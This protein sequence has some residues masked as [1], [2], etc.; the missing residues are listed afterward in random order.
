MGDK[1]LTVLTDD[2]HLMLAALLAGLDDVFEG[3]S[4]R[5][6]R[7]K[8]GRNIHLRL[9][10]LKC[11][12]ASLDDLIEN[13]LLGAQRKLQPPLAGIGNLC[14]KLACEFLPLGRLLLK[15][16]RSSVSRRSSL[17]SACTAC[18]LCGAR[19]FSVR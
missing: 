3:M 14:R 2:I 13:G 10:V 8:L 16:S 5:H 9:G 15:L 19:I 17:A 18:A 1:P 7:R 4:L 6:L 11:T 12:A